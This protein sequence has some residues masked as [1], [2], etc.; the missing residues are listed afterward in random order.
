MRFLRAWCSRLLGVFAT[1]RSE[2][3]L[4]G[5]LESHLQLHI[6]D[7]VRAG[8]TPQEARRRAVMALGGVE[9]TKEAVPRSARAA[10]SRIAGCA[11][12]ATACARCIKSPGFT[13]AGVLILG[14]GIGVNAAIFTRRQRGRAAAAAVRRTPIASCGCGTRRRRRCS[15]IADLRALAGQLHR[16]GGAEPGRSSDGDLPRRPPDADRPGRAGRRPRP[17]ARR[18]I[19]CRS[20]ALSPT[21]GRGFTR[22]DDREGGPRTAHPERGVLALA[23]RRRSVGDRPTI[24][25]NRVPHTVIGVVPPRRRSSSAVQVWVPLQWTAD[26][27]AIRNNHNYR[28]IAK[29][30]PGVDVAQRAGRPDG[31]LRSGSQL[32]YPDDNKDWGALVRAAAGRHDR[33]RRARRCWCCS[34]PSRSCC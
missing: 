11:T 27:R 10:A 23:V 18:R 1:A 26:E 4:A 32:Q 22:D 7:N 17:F 3:E 20:S 19:S 6:D 30:K 24:M 8:M 21:L 25:L 5:E 15:P 28:G 16:L 29:L 34:A 33:R 13:L 12:C 2:R 14:L 9:Q 31:D